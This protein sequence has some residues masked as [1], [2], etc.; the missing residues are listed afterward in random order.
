LLVGSYEQSP[1]L[2]DQF[3]HEHLDSEFS[4]GPGESQLREDLADAMRESPGVPQIRETGNLNYK[5][6]FI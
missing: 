2:M 6:Y 4:L 5:F 3:K 1:R